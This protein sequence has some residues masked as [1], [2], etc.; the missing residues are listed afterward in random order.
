MCSSAAL[1]GLALSLVLAATGCSVKFDPT[2]PPAPAGQPYGDSL[3]V[4]QA[5]RGMPE[6]VGHG[7]FTVFAI[8]VAP[9]TFSNGPGA[10]VFMDQ[11][12]QTFEAAGYQVVDASSAAAVPRV[13]CQIDEFDFSNYTW[14]FPIV[15]TWGGIDLTLRLVDASGNVPWEKSYSGSSWNLWY[16]FSS[17][18]NGAAEKILEQVAEDARGQEFRRACCG[19]A[20]Q[21]DADGFSPP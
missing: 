9:V 18:V 1:Q 13:E 2:I 5:A 8:E 3:A 15:P 19:G 12:E 7:R 17:A 21:G 11:I 20:E 4:E 14:L 16:S 6:V 10:E